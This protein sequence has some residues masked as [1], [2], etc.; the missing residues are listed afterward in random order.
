V[1]V[2]WQ[3][4]RNRLEGALAVAE[5]RDVAGQQLLDGALARQL[6]LHEHANDGHCK[7]S[8]IQRR[9]VW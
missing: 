6:L 3:L 4:R 7:Y 2:L 9:R 5:R 8:V 1:E